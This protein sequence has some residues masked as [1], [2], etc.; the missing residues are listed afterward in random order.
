[1]STST[2]QQF[3]KK[4]SSLI[5]NRLLKTGSVLEVRFWE[6]AGM[7]EIDL[8]L[9]TVAMD[10]WEEVPYM[11]CRV[12][13]FTYRDYTP[14]GW[15]A[16][17]RTCTLYIDTAHQGPG[18]SWARSL[19]PDDLISYIGISSTRHRPSR[20]SAVICLGDESSMGHLLALRQLTLPETRFA[21]AVL[22][23][24]QQ[25]CALFQQ[26]FHTSLAPF[27]KTGTDDHLALLEWV[28]TQNIEPESASFI[29][30]GKSS[31]VIGLRK[32]LKQLGY[33]S[34]QIKAHG[35]WN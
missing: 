14:S 34:K 4:A 18:S 22:M 23:G 7:A 9:P 32:G 30:A 10:Q 5:E 6:K 16:Q 12:A 15:D 11:K 21:G 20:T 31:L 28:N 27:V 13:D 8:H 17:T 25:Q 2:L 24:D 19:R 29:L 1:M 33:N 3:R 26:Y 35:F